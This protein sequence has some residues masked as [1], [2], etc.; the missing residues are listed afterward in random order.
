MLDLLKEPRR[1]DRLRRE[2]A[3]VMSG[4]VWNTPAG[5]SAF[6]RIKAPANL[7][8]LARQVAIE[9]AD[10]NGH[11]YRFF[12]HLELAEFNRQARVAVPE[13]GDDF[14]SVRDCKTCRRLYAYRADKSMKL[15]ALTAAAAPQ[16][17][18]SRSKR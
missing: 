4:T 16:V 3:D 5:P 17:D 9:G 7:D 1:G 6:D 8:E 2:S 13:H 11:E 14:F 15:G 10:C 12:D 18:F